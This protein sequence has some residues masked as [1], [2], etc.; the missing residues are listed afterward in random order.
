MRVTIQGETIDQRF[1]FSDVAEVTCERFSSATL[2][3]TMCPPQPPSQEWR[4]IMERLSIESC[5]HY[6]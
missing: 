3:A 1:G 2:L 4:D 6:R 5:S